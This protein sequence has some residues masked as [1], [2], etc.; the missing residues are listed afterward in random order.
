MYDSLHDSSH[1]TVTRFTAWTEN[2][3]DKMY[4]DS[5]SSPGLPCG[6]CNQ[7]VSTVGLLEQMKQGCLRASENKTEVF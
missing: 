5:F 7:A 1:A 3:G 4:M 6:L 2:V